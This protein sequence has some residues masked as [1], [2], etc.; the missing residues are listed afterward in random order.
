VFVKNVRKPQAAGGG[1][2]SHIVHMRPRV[3]AP[4][5]IFY[6]IMPPGTLVPEGLMF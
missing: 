4:N 5:C 3:S 1:G 2:L 6:F